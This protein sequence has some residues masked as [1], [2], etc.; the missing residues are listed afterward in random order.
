MSDLKE[1]GDIMIMGALPIQS[2]K[3]EVDNLKSNLVKCHGY[4]HV[5]FNFF[6]LSNLNLRL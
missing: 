6:E 2:R 5:I 4:I 3:F 1:I